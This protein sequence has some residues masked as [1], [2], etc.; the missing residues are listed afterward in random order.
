MIRTQHRSLYHRKVRRPPPPAR[1]QESLPSKPI[2]IPLAR[3]GNETDVSEAQMRACGTV[4]ASV[5]RKLSHPKIAILFSPE[6]NTKYGG[7]PLVFGIT[8]QAILNSFAPGQRFSLQACYTKGNI[9]VPQEGFA[10]ANINHRILHEAH[11]A[12]LDFLSLK[13]TLEISNILLDHRA[14]QFLKCGFGPLEQLTVKVKNPTESTESDEQPTTTIEIK[15]VLEH[16]VSLYAFLGSHA[17]ELDGKP[18][19]HE[20]HGRQTAE[21]LLVESWAYFI[22]SPGHL[23]RCD[24]KLYAAIAEIETFINYNQTLGHDDLKFILSRHLTP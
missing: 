4:I 16:F 24:P 19:D 9:F 11:H 20:Q 21:E 18:L 10:E 2:H 17:K 5:I 23:G 6:Q 3:F 7:K 15:K 12:L 14:R 22:L 8:N 13:P 1:Q